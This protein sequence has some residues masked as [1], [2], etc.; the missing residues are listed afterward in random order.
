MSDQLE[1]NWEP[2]SPPPPSRLTRPTEA[3]APLVLDENAQLRA[4]ATALHRE[5]MEATGLPLI[6]KISNNSS[7]M[8]SV[9][10]APDGRSARV[11]LHHMF[12][13]ASA[14][15]RRALAQ[16]IRKPKARKSATLLDSFIRQQRDQIKPSRT[17][18]TRL[19]PVGLHHDLRT[20]YDELNG[21]YFEDS[22][23]AGITWGKMP[24][25]RRRTSIRFGSFAPED[26]LIRLHPL[27]DQDFVPPHFVRYIVFH[28]ML[29]AFLGIEELPEGRRA[30]HT[31]QFKRLEKDYP[32]YEEAVAWM[33]DS[34]NLNR[35]LQAHKTR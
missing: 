28:E 35:L 19:R 27:L 11:S 24:R 14:E 8:M 26:N 25:L 22:V 7:T 33:Q 23:K 34:R 30:I 31:P 3:P 20:F 21:L 12:L 5:L 4:A 6:L 1:F 29:H 18:A 10:Y 2:D 9:R 15:V 17:R 16:W 13:R 32:G